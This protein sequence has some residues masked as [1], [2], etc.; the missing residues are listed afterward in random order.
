MQRFT[1]R[2]EYTTLP[3]R[4]ARTDGDATR[5]GAVPRM[6]PLSL[7][8]ARRD[9]VP[10]ILSPGL[11]GTAGCGA[12]P[13]EAPSLLALRGSPSLCGSEDVVCAEVSKLGLGRM[14]GFRVFIGAG[15]E[16]FERSPSGGRGLES[17]DFACM[18][19]RPSRRDR[20]NP[21]SKDASRAFSEFRDIES[22]RLLS[23]HLRPFASVWERAQLWRKRGGGASKKVSGS[24]RNGKA[25]VS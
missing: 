5:Q 10:Q 15:K 22:A 17:G 14:R 13:S 4:S 3:T 23:G 20:R 2:S 1:T 12:P 16:L 7:L 18:G 9:E 21:W 24:C 11:C 19:V 8:A 25:L 6:Q